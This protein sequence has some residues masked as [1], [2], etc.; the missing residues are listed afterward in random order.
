[1]VSAYF[2]ERRAL[3]VGV[4]MAG[5]SMGVLVC[6]LLLRYLVD[7]FGLRGALILESGLL[8][9]ICVT[10]A[11][12][13]PH[14][15]QHRDQQKYDTRE[16]LKDHVLAM[17]SC[18]K[19]QKSSERHL[20]GDTNDNCDCGKMQSRHK[21]HPPDDLCHDFESSNRTPRITM[22]RHSTNSSIV[23][24]CLPSCDATLLGN[25]RF[26]MQLLSAAT[27]HF[28]YLSI[29]VF[30]PPYAEQV[31]F[32]KDM[33]AVLMS[34]GGVIDLISRIL[35]GWFSD[36]SNVKPH[37]VVA[38]S[39]LTMGISCVL[40]PIWP[41]ISTV[42]TLVI[43]VSVFGAGYAALFTIVMIEFVGI[44]NLPKAYSLFW[45]TTGVMQSWMPFLL[46]ETVYLFWWC[47]FYVCLNSLWPSD[48]FMR[49]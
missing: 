43:L 37:I 22:V 46:G 5:V 20:P 31:G 25:P 19:I 28:A 2:R 38:S 18:G 48:A 33:V 12:F 24:N 34:T 27:G 32:S 49:Q 6:P 36:I 26:V 30:L 21:S 16:S 1:M 40:L 15:T 44:Q 4:M 42:W 7:E 23:R 47:F 3:A 13:Y 29:Y 10:G 45:L 8:L 41:S 17:C 14:D 11:L 9:N 35:F 39:F